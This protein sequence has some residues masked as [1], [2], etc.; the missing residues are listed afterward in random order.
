M[1]ASAIPSLP[2]GDSPDLVLVRATAE[3]RI[4]CLKLNSIAWKGPLDLD[5]Y[6]SRENLLL[7]QSLTRDSLTIWILVDRSE[8]EGKRTILS[9]CETYKKRALL[10]YNGALEDVVTHGIGCVYCRAEFRGKGYAKRMCEELGKKLEKWLVEE[11]PRGRS[12]FSILYSDI[13]KKFY[14]QLGWKPFPSAQFSLPAASAAG[15]AKSKTRDLFPTDVKSFMCN[16]TVM[17]KVREELQTA[18]QKSSNVQVA[19]IPD[20]DHFVWHWAREEFTAQKLLQRSQPVIKGAG[21]DDARV[22][23]VWNRNFGESPES[24]ILYILH[25]VYDEPKSVEEE[26]SLVQAIVGILERAQEEAHEWGLS[27]VEFWNP[28]PLLQKA[29][30]KLDPNIQL[31]HR[32]KSSICSLRWTGAEH[33]LSDDVDW[34]FNEKFAWC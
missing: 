32:E 26:S 27:K 12:L 31:V 13:G 6:I 4:E 28:S 3:E 10:A 23:A 11:Q 33:G 5:A 25:W 18:S 16:D 24:N 22:Y 14:T 9:A 34:L 29:V 8:P 21:N 7:N 17:T 15:A 2:A 20:F 1:T 19:V 30:A